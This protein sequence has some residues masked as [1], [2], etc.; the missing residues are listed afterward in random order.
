MSSTTKIAFGVFLG[1]VFATSTLGAGYYFGIDLPRKHNEHISAAKRLFDADLN[2][3]ARDAVTGL[4]TDQLES[5]LKE[6]EPSSPCNVLTGTKFAS[7][8]SF[9]DVALQRRLVSEANSQ[10][11][12]Q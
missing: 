6:E 8:A 1:V 10:K 3:R 4:T 2:E 11:S 7:C 12:P 5:Q 9:D